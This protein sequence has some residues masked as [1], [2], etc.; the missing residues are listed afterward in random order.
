MNEKNYLVVAWYDGPFGPKGT[1]ISRHG[2]Q[3]LA[4]RALKKKAPG[5]SGNW[6]GIRDKR[7]DEQAK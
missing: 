4:E 6:L 1:V 5:G 2:S 3:E 7:D